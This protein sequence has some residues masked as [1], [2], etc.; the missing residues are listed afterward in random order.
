ML[1]KHGFYTRTV[2]ENSVD[3]CILLILQHVGVAACPRRNSNLY[4]ASNGTFILKLISF[5]YCRPFP[6]ILPTAFYS[7]SCTQLHTHTHSAARTCT[8]IHKHTV[9]CLESDGIEGRSCGP[10]EENVNMPAL[11]SLGTQRMDSGC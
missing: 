10:S 3:C 11:V 1:W 6:L 5:S 7:S 8:Y 2:T 4:K 9:F